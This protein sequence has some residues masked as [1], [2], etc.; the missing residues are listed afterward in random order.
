MNPYIPPK[1]GISEK[2]VLKVVCI[3]EDVGS[4]VSHE[5]PCIE[6]T[7]AGKE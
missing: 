4:G 6:T 3:Q 5:S 2:R 1:K 7:K